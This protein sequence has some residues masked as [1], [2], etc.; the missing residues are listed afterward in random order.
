MSRDRY[1]QRVAYVRSLLAGE[2]DD[3]LVVELVDL[4]MHNEDVWRFDGA[5]V[6]EAVEVL[7]PTRRHALIL[8][9][10]DRAAAAAPPVAVD[11][12]LHWLA[13]G[14][15]PGALSWRAGKCLIDAT[16]VYVV[17]FPDELRVLAEVAVRETGA[18]PPELLGVMR[19]SAMMFSTWAKTLQPWLDPALD[20][21]NVG[22]PWAETANAQT[23]DRRL[24]VH[25]LAAKGARPA[26]A[27]ARQAATLADELG[28]ARCRMLI[29]HWCT[30]VPQPRTIRLRRDELYDAN[31]VLDAHNALAL[32]GL[33]YLLT[34]IPPH[35]DDPPIVGRL[36]QH[37]AEKV[38]GHGA[39]S[40]IV[41]YA[42]VHTLERLG[43]VPALRELQQLRHR[44]AQPGLTGRLDTAIA[45]R[46]AALGTSR[47]IP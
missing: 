47:P 2:D 46:S 4:A 5:A 42:A 45:R 1:P 35:P 22:E 13:R 24:L 34:V 30:L 17:G 39:R 27:W 20:P 6:R 36:A 33:L 29:H 38:P 16:A 41:A 40:Q 23:P 44:S 37:V 7:P 18:V 8:E 25:A 26:A 14:L 31:E 19:R 32:R 11:A 3:A 15:E 28:V 10:A 9:V 43:T 12:L 21:L